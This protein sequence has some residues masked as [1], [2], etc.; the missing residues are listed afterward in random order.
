ME[1]YNI[2][3][4]FEKC[5]NLL[6]SDFI[7]KISVTVYRNLIHV[8]SRFLPNF[9]KK[10]FH[11]LIT[12]SNCPFTPLTTT[13]FTTSPDNNS[14][15]IENARLKGKFHRAHGPGSKPPARNSSCELDSEIKDNTKGDAT[16][17]ASSSGTRRPRVFVGG[18]VGAREKE[19]PASMRAREFGRA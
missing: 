1:W 12:V 19:H 2:S 18:S 4:L 6:D 11:R 13:P 14:P 7:L 9:K 17:Q 15:N 16:K 3:S 8:S 5:Y 10:L